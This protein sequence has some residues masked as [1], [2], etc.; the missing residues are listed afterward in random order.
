M[1]R[2]KLLAATGLLHLCFLGQAQ[3]PIKTTEVFAS[4]KKVADWQ[5]NVLDTGRWK[6][7]KT[8]WTNAAYYTGQMAWAQ[9]ANDSRHLQFLKKIGE[10]NGWK[11]GPERFFADDY[12][13]GQTYAQLYMLYK[14]TVMIGEMKRIADEIIVRPHTESLMWNFAGGLHNREWAW[15]DA[16]FM[17]PPMLAYLS[18]ATR[19]QKYLDIANRLW[20][21]SADFLYDKSE[22]LFFRDSRFF[23]RKEKNGQKVFWS[24]GNGWVIAGITRMLNNMP[25]NYKDRSRY[26][27]LYKAL[28]KRIAGLQQPDG[29]WHASLLDPESYPVKETSGTGFFAYALAW[30]INNGLLSYNEYFPVVQKAWNALNDCVHPNGKLGFVQVPGAAPEKVTFDDTETYGV[31]AY[32]L[33]GTELFKLMYQRETAPMKISVRNPTPTDRTTE[34]VETGWVSFSKLKFSPDAIKVVNAQT[35]EEVPSQVVYAGNKTPQGFIFPAGVTAGSTGYFLIQKEKSSAYTAKTFGRLVPE[36]MDDFAWEN[37]LVA[38]RMYGPALQASG[39]ISSGIDVWGKRTDKLVIN[40]W[41]KLN[42]YHKDHGEG[43]DFY[44]VGTT[45]GAGGTAPFINGTLYPSQNFLTYK[46][47]DNGPLRT[48]FQ[49]VYKPWKAGSQLISETKTITLDAGTFFNRIQES[50]RF[51]GAALPIAIGIATLPGDNQEWNEVKGSASLLAY[52]QSGPYGAINLGVVLPA[53]AKPLQVDAVGEK[54][55]YGHTG[56]VML[57]TNYQQ[58]KPFVYYQGAAWDKQGAI[59]TTNEWIQHLQEKAMQLQQPLIIKIQTASYK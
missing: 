43:M 52:R 58:G 44:G 6:Y 49:L 24:R 39:E 38:F 7:R 51:S 3:V 17:G 14:D 9:M 16:L 55:H 21:R 35:G 25:A 5:V 47:L 50:Y 32:L 2:I 19:E 12:C 28:A 36:R 34:M 13:V 23:D 33:A 42:D 45:L 31:G 48:S 11:G 22:Q 15:C 10:A 41:Y 26:V 40:N 27:Q 29:T 20:W 54:D 30:G 59:R 56:H 4:L 18:T 37:D 8:D 46:V 57:A 53:A 1:N